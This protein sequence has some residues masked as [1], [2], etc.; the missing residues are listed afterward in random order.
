MVAAVTAVVGVSEL[1]NNGNRLIAAL[2][3][4]L[5]IAC[6]AKVLIKT[7]KPRA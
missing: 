3:F 6:V 5:A 2:F 7:R 1:A 4:G